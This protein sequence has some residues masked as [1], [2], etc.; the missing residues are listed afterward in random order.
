MMI[1]I[2][3][4]SLIADLMRILGKEAFIPVTYPGG[5]FGM[6]QIVQEVVVVG[7]EDCNDENADRFT[8]GLKGCTIAPLI[9]AQDADADGEPYCNCFTSI[10]S[11]YL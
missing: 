2:A 3:L 7:G 9:C 1:A 8:F 5:A 10:P 6:Q 4:S 11:V